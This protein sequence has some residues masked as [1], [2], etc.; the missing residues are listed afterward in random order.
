MTKLIR[1]ENLLGGFDLPVC[2]SSERIVAGMSPATLKRQMS[3]LQRGLCVRVQA[4]SSS[5]EPHPVNV[6]N[7]TLQSL[8]SGE[9]NT[10]PAERP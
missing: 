9:E 1:R 3:A 10:K 5:K 8:L 6:R 2:V 4:A 7:L